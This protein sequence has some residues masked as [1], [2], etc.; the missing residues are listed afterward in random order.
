MVGESHGNDSKKEGLPHVAT[1]ATGYRIYTGLDAE[2]E[3][4][5]NFEHSHEDETARLIEQ[6]VLTLTGTIP[7]W[8]CGTL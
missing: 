3:G 8:C 1:M 4:S 2:A 5:W 6:E 7:W